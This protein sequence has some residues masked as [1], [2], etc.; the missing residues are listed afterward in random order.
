[1]RDGRLVGDLVASAG[2]RSGILRGN[3]LYRLKGGDAQLSRWSRAILAL[4]AFA[5]AQPV[6]TGFLDRHIVV[7][8]TTYR[9]SVYVPPDFSRD[10]TWPVLV[11][12]HGNGA[13][14]ADGIRQTAH[15]LGES[16]RMDRARFPLLVV[17]P[18]AARET[19]WSTA[20]MQEMVI[21]E[22]DRVASEFHGDPKRTYLSG[23][24]M[25]GAG[26]YG[27]AARWPDRFAALLA[28]AGAV[29]ADDA[30][31]VSRLRRIPLRIV[32]GTDDERVPV[33]G[34]RRLAGDLK[35]ASAPVVYVEYSGTRHGPTAERA[36]DDPLVLEWLLAQHKP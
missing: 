11:D 5:P 31:L 34:A 15:F 23:F 9:F 16:I 14:G 12:L 8:G 35:K 33:E 2:V 13:Q 26:V 27:I 1:M 22:L 36:Y 29:P 4:L 19:S 28:I 18:Q 32:H 17:F 7:A 24:S 30:T 25:G 20:A 21:A 6:E 10:N 3:L